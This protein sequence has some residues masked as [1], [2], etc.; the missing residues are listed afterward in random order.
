MTPGD[1]LPLL[2]K[3]E[4][5]ECIIHDTGD[6]TRKDYIAGN[7]DLVTTWKLFLICWDPADG[8]QM[9]TAAKRVMKIFGGARSV[10]TVATSPGLN[11][12][13]QTLVLIPENGSINPN[14]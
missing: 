9:N 8:L 5:L 7:S 10:E 1:Q 12:R 14:P 4:G 11:A 13:V 2:S 6:I 3:Q